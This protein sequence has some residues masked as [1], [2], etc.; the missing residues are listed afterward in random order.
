MASP[1]NNLKVAREG[2]HFLLTIPNYWARGATM[3]E[4]KAKLKA[5]GG[6]LGKYWRVNSVEPETYVNELGQ[7]AYKTGHAPIMLAEQNPS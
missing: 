7:I 6:R 1:S 4:A 5:A 2:D 3:A